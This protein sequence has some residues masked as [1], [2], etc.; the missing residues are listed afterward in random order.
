MESR[1]SE[2]TIV[3]PQRS[4]VVE[5]IAV[6][7]TFF[8]FPLQLIAQL[9]ILE[10]VQK[11]L[12][13]KYGMMNI[14]HYINTTIDLCHMNAS[15]PAVA[16]N[17]EVQE[18]ASYINLFLTLSA[19]VPALFVSLFLGAYSDKAGRKYAIL[20]PLVG[21][22][23][24]TV[25]YII[26][27]QLHLPLWYLFIAAFISGFGGFLSTMLLGCFAYISDTTSP[28][29]R[30][31]RITVLEM[32]LMLPG[33]IG[34]LGVGNLIE[35]IGYMY[36]F[37]ISL[38]GQTIIVIYVIFFVPETVQ[39]DPSAKFFDLTRMKQ[40]W[41]LFTKTDNQKRNVKLIILFVAFFIGIMPKFDYGLDTLYLKNRPLCMSNKLVGYYLSTFLAVSTFGGIFV[42]WLFKYCLSDQIVAMIGGLSSMVQNVYKTFVQNVMMIFFAPVF[43]AFSILYIPT[44]RSLLS[45]TVDKSEQGIVFGVVAF[46]ELMCAIVA[47]IIFNPIY[48]S[49]QNI[50]TGFVY[51]VMALFYFTASCVLMVYIIC[52]WH[53]GKSN[54]ETNVVV[55]PER[56]P[57]LGSNEHA[58]RYVET[59]K[60]KEQCT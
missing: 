47:V 26:V 39:K 20:P 49:T 25:V 19:S 46:I 38:V 24:N 4:I 2:F 23:V 52:Y 5:P 33:I 30:R 12:A 27:V 51:L 6:L 48:A 8:T 29:K 58:K 41:Q 17:A 42:A 53:D 16:F 59:D 34:P 60:E 37:V 28:D 43:S 21:T 7:Y 10:A 15:D 56:E 31:F 18:N 35:T 54:P 45:N 9:Y 22:V 11:D 14:S 3:Q 44:V 55:N 36:S 40:F 50:L 13:T 32:C 1:N 57:L